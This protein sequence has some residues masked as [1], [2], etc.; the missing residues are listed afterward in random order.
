VT[1]SVL[2]G[3]GFKWKGNGSPESGMGNWHNEETG[4]SLHP[5]LNHEPPKGSHWGYKGPDGKFDLY[6]DGRVEPN[7]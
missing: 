5:D 4:V 2:S 1:W 6:P 3:P 7:G